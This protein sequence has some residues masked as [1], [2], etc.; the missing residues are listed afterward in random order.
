[1]TPVKALR[2]SDLKKKKQAKSY[3]VALWSAFPLF[4]VVHAFSF[5]SV[6]CTSV[7]FVISVVIGRGNR[8][9]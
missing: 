3:I 5:S 9:S 1:M 4:V 7:V 8:R 2:P 6:T